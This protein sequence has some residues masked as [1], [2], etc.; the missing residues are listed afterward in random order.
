[1]FQFSGLA[2]LSKWYTFSVTGCPIRKSRDILLVCSS[3]WLIAAY[4]VLHRLIDPRHPPYALICFKKVYTVLVSYHKLVQNRPVA[5]A[6]QLPAMSFE[7]WAI[8]DYLIT[9]T[10]TTYFPNMSKNLSIWKFENESIWKLKHILFKWFLLMFR[11][12]TSLDLFKSH[13]LFQKNLLHLISTLAN[14]HI[15][16]FVFVEDIGVEPMTLCVQGRC[17]SQLS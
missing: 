10:I 6:F 4:H 11:L 1:M 16:T 3:P 8:T 5:I 14:Y 17:S 7:L 12:R 2:L 15:I 13:H 9:S